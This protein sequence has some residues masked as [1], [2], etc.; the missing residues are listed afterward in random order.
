MRIATAVRTGMLG[1]MSAVLTVTAHDSAGGQVPGAPALAAVIVA[2]TFLAWLVSR[3]RWALSSVVV[4]L[5]GCQLASHLVLET[6]PAPAVTASHHHHGL[7]SAAT[8]DPST[9]VPVSMIV[10]HLGVAL[11][12]AVLL[13]RAEHAAGLVQAIVVWAG[14]ALARLAPSLAVPVL[15]VRYRPVAMSTGHCSR[16]F[17]VDLVYGHS[18]RGPPRSPAPDPVR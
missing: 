11:V 14:T 9:G 3:H 16:R 15:P 6:L 2:C 1:F 10:A 18:R 8:Q 5:G 4:L 7:S 17:G 12:S 13:C